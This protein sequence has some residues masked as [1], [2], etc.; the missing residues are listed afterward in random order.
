MLV[1]RFCYMP[2]I[3]STLNDRQLYISVTEPAVQKAITYFLLLVCLTI[4]SGRVSAGVVLG[5]KA[6]D[7]QGQDIKGKQHRLSDYAGKIVVLEWSSP[8][9]PYSRRYYTNGTLDSL[10]D[11]A[12]QNGIIWIN[13]VPKL[14][15]LTREQALEHMDLSKKIIILDNNLDISTAFG[16]TTTPQIL[17]VNRRGILSYSG[18]IDSTAMLKQTTGKVKPYTRNALDDLLADRE[19]NKQITRAFGCFVKNNAQPADALPPISRNG[20]Q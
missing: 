9:C 3:P 11:F 14:Q 2:L 17:I 1:E 18:A 20:S 16:A 19:V 13:I 12:K 7:F 10:Y 4:L 8:E 5:T 6:P 15:K